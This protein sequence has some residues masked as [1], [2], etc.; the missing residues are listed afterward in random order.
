MARIS[1]DKLP[2]GFIIENGKVVKVMAHGGTTGDQSFNYSLQTVPTSLIGDQ[3]NK[4]GDKKVRYSLG[5]VDRDLANLEAE[6]GETVLTD[7]NDKG[8]FGLYNITGPSHDDGG[9]PMRLPDQSFIFSRDPSMEIEP[10]VLADAFGIN[11][12]KSMTPAQVSRK[13]QLNEYNVRVS[14][15]NSDNITVDTAETMLDKNK[16]SLSKLA[17][18]QES[19]KRFADG[20][21]AASFPFLQSQGVNPLE[22]KQEIEQKSQQEVQQAMLNQLP[23]EERQQIMQQAQF[24]MQM[25]Q[26]EAQRQAESQMQQGMQQNVAAQPNNIEIPDDS[27]PEAEQGGAVYGAD[28][29]QLMSFMKDMIGHQPVTNTSDPQLA[30]AYSGQDGDGRPD[31]TFLER[32]MQDLYS[33]MSENPIP[34]FDPNLMQRMEMQ[35]QQPQAKYGLRKHQTLGEFEPGLTYD[36]TGLFDSAPMSLEEEA[37]LNAQ[38]LVESGRYPDLTFEDLYESQIS[39]LTLRDQILD[40]REQNDNLIKDFPSLKSEGEERLLEGVYEYQNLGAVEEKP[41]APSVNAVD[42]ETEAK[43]EITSDLITAVQGVVKDLDE[44]EFDII[45]DYIFDNIDALTAYLT[46]NPIATD[47]ELQS[48]ILSAAGVTPSVSDATDETAEATTETDE[49]FETRGPKKDD[50]SLLEELFK[51]EDEQ[52]KNTTDVAY[53]ALKSEAVRQGVSEDQIPTKEEMVNKFLSYQNAIYQLLDKATLEER[54]DANLDGRGNVNNRM[55]QTLLD[56]YDINYTI[57]VLDTKLNQTFS[58]AL[59]VADED[60]AEPYLTIQ[61]LGPEQSSNWEKNK[62]FSPVDGIFGNNTANQ[63]VRVTKPITPQEEPEGEPEPELE[64]EIESIEAGDIG[65]PAPQPTAEMFIQDLINL[66][67][68]NRRERRLG[69]PFEPEVEV[70]KFEQFLLDPTREIAGLTEVKNITDQALASF[71]PAQSYLARTAKTSADTMANIANTI[72]SYSDKNATIINQGEYQLASIRSNNRKEKRDRDK[73]LYDNTELALQTYVNEKNFDREQ[74]SDAFS[75]AI[76]NMANT[77]NINTLYPNFNINPMA[78]GMI[79]FITGNTLDPSQQS[80]SNGNQQAFINAARD[81]TAAGIPVNNANIKAYLTGEFVDVEEEDPYAD[82]KANP[83]VLG[84]QS[85]PTNATYNYGG[86]L[87]NVGM[88]GT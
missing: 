85:A 81:L 12:S 55:A 53:A 7:L 3:V 5:S 46:T 38:A 72:S 1:I 87:F 42:P 51:S 36:V 79:D 30:F 48:F 57:D 86:G 10:Q 45:R 4:D 59:F 43:S 20:V 21:P 70:D 77:Y 63:F 76:T 11:T 58:Q 23:P 16:M 28:S 71:A 22:F 26:A 44:G 13:F 80:T 29:S 19:T 54:T 24:M 8:Q 50:Y 25:Q 83:T 65:T 39:N 17:F 78:G 15:S 47:E 56:K 68:I 64:P 41:E 84:Y 32:R 88:M 37:R 2:D 18:I 67:K 49:D 52:W 74:Y 82:I 9:V 66:D 14:D 61:G 73:A 75:N 34:H 35:A 31:L 27:L 69:L 33:D 40:Q 6:G 60:N 62:Q